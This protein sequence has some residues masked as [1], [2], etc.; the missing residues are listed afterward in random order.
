MGNGVRGDWDT[1]RDFPLPIRFKFSSPVIHSESCF[2]V[3]EDAFSQRWEQTLSRVH[4]RSVGS[5]FDLINS[6]GAEVCPNDRM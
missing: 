3:K 2:F 4:F 5:K 6:P 1:G